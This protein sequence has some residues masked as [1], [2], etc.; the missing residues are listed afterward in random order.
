MKKVPRIINYI[1]IIILLIITLILFNTSTSSITNDDD[2][3]ETADVF[4]NNIQMGFNLGMSF[5]ANIK[6]Q[7][8]EEDSI[9]KVTKYE[10]MWCNTI[11]TKELFVS[12][13]NR[14]FNLIR[15]SVDIFNHIKDNIIDELWLKRIEEVINWCVDLDLYIVINII[16][17][18]G[19][20]LTNE[21]SKIFLKSDGVN[22]FKIFWN[23]LA[24]RFKDIDG[25]LLFEPFNEL[26]NVNKDWS[27]NDINE[28]NNLNSL[29]QIF[30]DI[31]RSNGGYNRYR[32]LILPTY[33]ASPKKYLIDGLRLP[34]DT[35]PN[36]LIIDVHLYEPI[37]F[38]FNETNLKSRD[39]KYTFGS[40]KDIDNL[41][42]YFINL[43]LSRN[44]KKVPIL[45]GE[46][47]VVNLR[48]ISQIKNYLECYMANLKKYN[49]KA[50]YFDDSWD[51]KIID[52]NNFKFNEDILNILIND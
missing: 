23:D 47:G 38:C 19:L 36:H 27:T 10:L 52:R 49:I 48:N 40:K 9:Q 31:I 6:D 14:G 18:Y 1:F 16:E 50:V 43:N 4:Y 26:I 21:E 37:N 51:F 17:T 41:N 7:V 25:H 5:S 30:V 29:Y 33:G 28:I 35:V 8:Y 11:T 2:M 45:I 24:K 22:K 13:K 3:V 32:N 34:F 42:N 20:E 15:I 12:L 39:F 46:F 44:I